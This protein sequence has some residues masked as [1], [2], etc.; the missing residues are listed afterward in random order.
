MARHIT[1]TYEP[2]KPRR[3]KSDTCANS[4]DPDE[5]AHNEPSHQDPHCL[6]SFFFFFFILGRSSFVSVSMYIF[7]DARVHIRNSGA[8][9]LKKDKKDIDTH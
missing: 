9:G 5:T 1:K 8:Q 6:S 2:F 3:P 4:V 7:N